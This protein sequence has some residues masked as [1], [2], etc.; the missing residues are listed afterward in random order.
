M[1]KK[2]PGTTIELEVGTWSA[3][4]EVLKSLFL[5]GG[6]MLSQVA[7]LSGLAPY[8]VQNWVRR[9]FLPPPRNK[10]YSR[11]QLS[12]IFIINTLRGSLQIDRICQLLG[13]INGHLDDESDDSIDDT[14]LYLYLIALC[15]AAELG[16][17][18]N[19]AE[20]LSDY[21]EPYEGARERVE[22]VLEIMLMAY[23]AADLK[24]RAEDMILDL[25]I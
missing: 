8:D 15:E 23:R 16:R 24:A 11:R 10:L 18:P 3:A 9:G 19:T 5:S 25:D 12:R 2:L 7:R 14:A 17:E 4:D 6:L 1:I 20:L 21:D 22:K 13:Y